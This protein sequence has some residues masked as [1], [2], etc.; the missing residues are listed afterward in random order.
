MR[1]LHCWDVITVPVSVLLIVFNRPET[2]EKVLQAI[3]DWDIS[4]LYIAADGPRPDRPEDADLCRRTRGLALE[5]GD[6]YPTRTLFRNQNLGCGQ[7]VADAITWFFEHEERG[8]ILEDDCV[9]QADFARYCE[10]LLDRYAFD[11]QVMMASGNNFLRG[12]DLPL[13]SYTF[14]SHPQIWGWATWRR[15]WVH[16]DYEMTDWPRLRQSKW[17]RRVC[18]GHRFT[19]RYW[20]RIFDAVS[21]G[22]IDSW[23]YR[24]VYSVWNAKGISVMPP[25]NL[26]DNVGFGPS[27]SHTPE[28]PTW[29]ERIPRGSLEFP[30]QR[31]VVVAS[32]P[33]VDR[34]VETQIFQTRLPSQRRLMRSFRH[35]I[36]RS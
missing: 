34:L 24:W 8:I 18:D 30:L 23:A 6:R 32:N 27:A 17:L 4:R 16:F 31:P 1:L 19:E 36:L 5:L 15:A 13:N 2:T 20:K 25:I 26:V 29:Y 10:T 22:E 3:R 12:L 9:P 7:G 35:R 28:I 33:R 14:S 21:R 11:D